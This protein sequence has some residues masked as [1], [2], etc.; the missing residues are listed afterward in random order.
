VISLLSRYFNFKSFEMEKPKETEQK[1]YTK[2]LIPG[3][4]HLVKNDDT[5]K[6]LLK[7]DEKLCIVEHYREDG[8][9][10]Q[11][12]TDLPIEFVSKNIL[13]I[14]PKQHTINAKGILDQTISFIKKYLELPFDQGYLIL[15][16]WVF[17]TYLMEK[18]DVTPILYFFGTKETGKTRAG[19]TLSKIS[20]MSE[21]L[22]SPTEASLFRS[23][24]LFK[25]ALV[26]D[27][28]KL[29]GADGN[30]EVANLIKS[31]YKRGMKVSRINMNKQGE[32]QVEY[33][34]VF[35][36]LVICSTETMPPII[37]SR[38]ITFTM[39]QNTNKDV[40]G[41][42]NE[43]DALMIREM[44]TIF[45]YFYIDKE[46]PTVKAVTRRRLNEITRP[47]LQILEIVDPSRKDELIDYVKYLETKKA[48]EE[49]ESTE[50]EI[51]KCLIE[52]D[53]LIQGRKISTT[54]VTGVL[55]RE[56]DEKS[57]YSSRYISSCLKRL[58][59]DKVRLNDGKMGFKY[60]PNLLSRLA[61][62]Y[63]LKLKD[64]EGY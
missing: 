24:H 31:R 23:A 53:D 51:V 58:G 7:T 12:K 4:I 28:I 26:I 63:Q 44:L 40:E 41:D 19:E 3:L 8:K 55:N 38:C 13:E 33:Y 50:C 2:T 1:V 56:Q 46:L 11:P 62:K 14:I 5:L 52:E 15:A 43:G 54:A 6:Y 39:Q 30:K 47:L 34:D 27:E 22:T 49:S 32:D 61:I 9:V 36:P 59:F 10:F 35:A 48:D 18:F 42:I 37:E 16:L 29:W 25:T 60:D 45:R 17:H 64:T 57:K 20:F 21:R